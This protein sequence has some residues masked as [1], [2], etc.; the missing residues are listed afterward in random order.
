MKSL[1][2]MISFVVISAL[3]FTF[4]L[5]LFIGCNSLFN[6]TDDDTGEL[7]EGGTTASRTI[8]PEGGIIET[9]NGAKLDVPPGA[10]T[11]EVTITLSSFTNNSVLPDA[12]CP[13]PGMGGAVRL[14]PAGLE[15]AKP[16]TLT[17]PMD[18]EWAPGDQI[19]LFFFNSS[20]KMWDQTNDNVVINE[21]GH[22]FSSEISHFSGYGGGSVENLAGGG[23][24]EDFKND[25][26]DWF[27][28]NVLDLG[29]IRERENEC[30]ELVGMDFDLQFKS[31]SATGGD[32]WRVGKKTDNTDAPLMMVDY[33]YDKTNGN[34]VDGYVRITVTNYYECTK[35]MFLTRSDRSILME[36]ETTTVYADL[37]CAGT[38]LTGKSITF[39]IKS[40]DGTVSPGNTTTNSSGT[41]STT[42]TGGNDNSVVR[43]Y[44]QSCPMDSG[45]MLDRELMIAATPD[46]F[47]LAISFTQTISESDPRI[48]KVYSYGG[49]VT[50]TVGED[51]GDGSANIDGSSEF[52][53]SGGGTHEYDEDE[54]CT[55]D[56]SGKVTFTYSGTIRTDSVG[57]QKLYLTQTTSSECTEEETCPDGNV[58]YN[59]C[60]ILDGS[61]DFELPVENGYKIEQ[62]TGGGPISNE[63][64]YTLTF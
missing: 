58:H 26:T 12:W 31:N 37:S 2:V 27:R 23:G 44:Y 50:L 14:E 47:N 55:I 52:E 21:G 56:V 28:E 6:D 51:N 24:V 49:S 60:L 57:T 18:A 19:P 30:Y 53:I 4:L 8:G 20:S 17:V 11:E 64:N 33:I 35:P 36:G 45:E 43:A 38:A 16:A 1:R 61:V 22:S 10:L 13:I 15:F 41:A 42:F 54:D 32:V 34:T 29:N 46:Q 25:F 7:N 62:G 63:I 59:E 48:Y 40:G 5:Y 3:I 39:D 9:G